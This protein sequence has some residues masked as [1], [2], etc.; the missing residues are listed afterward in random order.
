MPNGKIT[1]VGSSGKITGN[2]YIGGICG[3]C[4]GDTE[5]NLIFN[6]GAISGNE[7]VGGIC[8]GTNNKMLKIKNVYNRGSVNE[9]KN[10]ENNGGIVGYNNLNICVCNGY[11]LG[12]IIA[13]LP[14]QIGP[15]EINVEDAYFI[16]G[17]ENIS[18]LGIEKELSLFKALLENKN[19]LI[20]MLETNSPNTWVIKYGYNDGY[21]M[22]KWELE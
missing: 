11:N 9:K 1:K 21:P 18:G 20:Y 22:F 14:N 4:E 2:K 17:Y 19:S 5:I 8:G 15:K 6:M 10:S 16:K 7:F 12:E 3:F 13:S